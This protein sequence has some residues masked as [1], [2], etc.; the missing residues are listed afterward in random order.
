MSMA[1]MPSNGISPSLLL[2]KKDNL[3]QDLVPWMIPFLKWK[4]PLKI[5]LKNYDT[6]MKFTRSLLHNHEKK[7]NCKQIGLF[8]MKM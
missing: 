5:L 8:S 7:S 4:N 1:L 2:T 3:W 6:T